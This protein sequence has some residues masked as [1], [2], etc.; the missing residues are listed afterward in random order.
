[1]RNAVRIVNKRTTLLQYGTVDED[2]GMAHMAWCWHS[3]GLSRSWGL[4]IQSV[5]KQA[6]P[7]ILT[8][9]IAMD[10]SVAGKER[11]GNVV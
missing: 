9:M 3:A 7:W 8:G 5:E 10:N 6:T 2:R 1:M 4:T 11:C